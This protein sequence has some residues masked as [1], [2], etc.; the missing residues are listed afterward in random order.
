[1][2]KNPS[3][4]PEEE[5][6]IQVILEETLHKGIIREA[7]HESTKFLSPVFLVKKA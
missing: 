6:E 2:R 5:V 4:S 7:I 3:F 1:M